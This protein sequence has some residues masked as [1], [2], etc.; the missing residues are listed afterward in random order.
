MRTHQTVSAWLEHELAAGRLMIGSRLPGERTMAEQLGISRASVREGTRVLEALGVVRAGV[1]SGPQSGTIVTGNPALALD[2]ALRLHV[3][4]AHLP[5][6]D[7]VE[8]R[9]LLEVWAAEHASKDSPALDRAAVLLDEMDGHDDAP[10]AFLERDALF[11]VALAEAAGN[12]LVG[13]MMGSLRGSIAGYTQ[14][15]TTRLP[16]WDVTS[17]RLRREHRAILAAVVAGEGARAAGLVRDHIE[18]FYLEAGI[19]DRPDAG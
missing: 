17:G 2:S 10:A 16:A 19:D 11:H 3:A 15:L 13:A 4:S 18:G 8:T 7:I 5:V 14:R 1:G 6:R 12:V 9:L